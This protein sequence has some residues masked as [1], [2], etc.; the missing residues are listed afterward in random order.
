M[1]TPTILWAETSELVILTVEVI[2]SQDEMIVLSDDNLNIK[3]MSDNREYY[4]DLDLFDKIDKTKSTTNV[5]IRNI[6]FVLYKVE[7]IRWGALSQKKY[8]N[9]YTDWQKWS[10]NSD[11]SDLDSNFDIDSN[12]DSED[13]ANTSSPKEFEIENLSDQELSEC[14]STG[15][16]HEN[17]TENDNLE[18]LQAD[19]LEIGDIGL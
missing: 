2:N 6:E 16:P 3:G 8:N 17:S 7:A 4:L 13:D 19:N 14:E 12:N 10:I 1:F 15:E 18:T 11:E 5:N 9:I